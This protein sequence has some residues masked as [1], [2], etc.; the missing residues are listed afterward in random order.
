MQQ[1]LIRLY[2]SD[3]QLSERMPG[4]A[5]ALAGYIGILSSK[6]NQP[7]FE[8]SPEDNRAAVVAISPQGE[9][10]GWAINGDGDLLYPD[11]SYLEQA[12]NEVDPPAVFVAPI[13]FAVHYAQT[14]PPQDW[15]PSP[16]EWIDHAS[17]AEGALSIDTVINLCL[18]DR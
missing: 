2:Q 7:E 5:A 17:G 4:G 18:R 14:A 1:L 10:I 8:T 6:L 13:V 15:V 3:V 11:Q 9:V 16:R 12:L